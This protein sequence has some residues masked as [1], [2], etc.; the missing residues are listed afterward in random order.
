MKTYRNL[1]PQ[2]YDFDNLY[3]AYRKARRGKRDRPEVIEFENNL[4]FELIQL[5]DQLLQQSWQP[6][7]YRQF[8]LYERKPRRISAAPFRDRVLHH[9]LCQVLE[10][11]WERRFIH[12][13]Y[14]C[15]YGKGTHAALDR[16]TY[17]LRRYRYCL[18]CDIMRFFPSM[19]H[20][21]LLAQ[22]QHYVRDPA[23]LEL[24]ETIIDSGAHIHPPHDGAW[25]FPGDDLIAQMRAKGL[26]IGN[27][28]S[29]F[30]AN[31]YLH[32][33]DEFVKRELRCPAYLRYCDDF[34]LFADDKKTL[35][36]WRAAIENFLMSLRLRIHP[37][38]TS[39]HP[40]TRGTAF[41][42]FTFYPQYRRLNRANGV[43]FQRRWRHLLG[44]YQHRRIGRRLLDARLRSW[45]AHSEHGDT[46]GLRRALISSQTI[47]MAVGI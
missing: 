25:L 11:I 4:E 29:Q 38:K 27:Q 39:V 13:S 15:R 8:T 6:G 40:V 32:A 12:D 16:C 10:P 20:D 17:F 24:C 23:L 30:W 1:Y 18:Q 21:I 9:A 46:W 47:F 44:A 36:E 7:H 34:L 43:R 37:N 3:R 26:P 2:V 14:A 31:V 35:H 45:I 33:L 42:G 28:T 19:D 5:Q 41:L 22:I